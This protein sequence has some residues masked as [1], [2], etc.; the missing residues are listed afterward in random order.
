MSSEFDYLIVMA[1]WLPTRS[2]A[3]S[4]FLGICPLQIEYATL[5]IKLSTFFRVH[6]YNISEKH[7]IATWLCRNP[8]L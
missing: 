2:P 1:S 8:Y 4:F 7:A 3:L 6:E 5:Q